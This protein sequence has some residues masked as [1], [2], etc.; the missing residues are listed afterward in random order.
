M[1]I[2][3]QLI[4]TRKSMRE[5]LLISLFGDVIRIVGFE[6]VIEGLI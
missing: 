3:M 1:L 2:D 5:L 4:R 6:G